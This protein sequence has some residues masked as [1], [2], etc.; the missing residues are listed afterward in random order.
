MRPWFYAI[1]HY[2]TTLDI[3]DGGKEG[4]SFDDL[5]AV[6]LYFKLQE[7]AADGT[8]A[9]HLGMFNEPV[10]FLRVMTVKDAGGNKATLV[11]EDGRRLKVVHLQDNAALY[12][13]MFNWSEAFNYS[14][15]IQFIDLDNEHYTMDLKFGD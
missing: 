8:F 2:G 14:T 4:M 5:N 6:K 7:M 13:G 10:L 9:D 1:Q 3:T 15:F 12:R 11:S